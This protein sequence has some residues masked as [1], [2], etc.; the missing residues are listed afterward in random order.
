MINTKK[1]DNGIPR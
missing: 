1:F